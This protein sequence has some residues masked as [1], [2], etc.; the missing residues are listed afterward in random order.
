MV[1]QVHPSKTAV[2]TDIVKALLEK[3]RS[4]FK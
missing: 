1:M 3:A 4:R 2:P